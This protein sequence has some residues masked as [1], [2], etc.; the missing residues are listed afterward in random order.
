MTG[1]CS[2]AKSLWFPLLWSVQS[3]WSGL[4]GLRPGED[5]TTVVQVISSHHQHQHI[6]FNRDNSGQPSE[7]DILHTVNTSPSLVLREVSRNVDD[8][9]WDTNLLN[10]PTSFSLLSVI[11]FY[12]YHLI[13]CF[14]AIIIISVNS[15]FLLNFLRAKTHTELISTVLHS[16]ILF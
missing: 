5:I 13:L 10:G 16:Y 9:Q 11:Y 4:R 2:K 6:P 7:Q 1:I 8:G 3:G 12:F 14:S 15:N